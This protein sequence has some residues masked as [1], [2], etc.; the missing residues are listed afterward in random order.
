MAMYIWQHKHIFWKYKLWKLPQE[1]IN[2]IGLF[3]LKHFIYIKNLPTKK[4]PSPDSFTS[5]FYHI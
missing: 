3:Y 2:L 1:E 5:E 4:T